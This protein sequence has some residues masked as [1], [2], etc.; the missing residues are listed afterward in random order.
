MLQICR[1]QSDTELSCCTGRRVL[2]LFPCRVAGAATVSRVLGVSKPACMK[3]PWHVMVV[4]A[5]ILLLGDL[6]WLIRAPRT[7]GSSVALTL[8]TNSLNQSSS[9]AIFRVTNGD[10]RAI[11]LTD[12]IVETNSLAG[13]QAFSHTTPTH[14]Q[15]LATADTKDLMIAFHRNRK[16][17][18]MTSAES[19]RRAML[20]AMSRAETNAPFYWA[21]FSLFGGYANY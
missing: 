12:L 21:A 6:F 9:G 19:L 2:V 4:L 7:I 17:N 5:A 15:L 14:P 3:K 18:G 1:C 20:E 13:W 11:L 10:G 8:V 16:Q